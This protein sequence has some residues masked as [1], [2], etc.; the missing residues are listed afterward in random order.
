M[1]SSMHRRDEKDVRNSEKELEGK[2]QLKDIGVVWRVIIMVKVKTVTVLLLITRQALKF[3][4]TSGHG[5]M[6]PAVSHTNLAV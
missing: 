1:A 5:S 4:G 2:C 3:M 6:E